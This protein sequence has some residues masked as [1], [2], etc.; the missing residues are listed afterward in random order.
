MKY[1]HFTYKLIFKQD[2]RYYYYGKHSTRN[3]ADGYCGS[4][5]EVQRYKQEYG[6]DCFLIQILEFF[7][8]KSEAL[9]AEEKLIADFWKTDP[10]CLN[11]TAGGAQKGLW[12]HEGNVTVTNGTIERRVDLDKL[13]VFESNGWYRGISEKHRISQQSKR[14]TE[15]QRHHLSEK[16]K[17]RTFSEET[18]KKLS[19]SHKGKKLSLLHKKA[20]SEGLSKVIKTE[21]WNRKNREAHLGKTGKALGKFWINNGKVSKMVLES[22]LDFWEK[23]GYTRG[24]VFTGRHYIRVNR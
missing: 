17:G 23:Q 11:R 22:E 19:E 12:D 16:L 6:K 18:R 13:G 1:Y 20:I 8:S 9:Q 15:E 10:F 7:S 21:E 24:R 5:I 14:L 4:G 2:T 3:L